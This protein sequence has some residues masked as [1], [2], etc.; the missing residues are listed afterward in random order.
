DGYFYLMR[1]LI[2]DS[3]FKVNEETSMV[4]AWISFPN[5]LPTFFVEECL[6][7][8]A[9]A[10]GKPIHLDQATINKTRPSCA[11]VKVL[12]D[13]KSDFPKAIQMNIDNIEMG[14]IRSNMVVI[15][16]D[17]VPKY[18]F[19]CKMQGHDKEN[20]KVLNHRRYKEHN[21]Q[22][23]QDKAQINHELQAGKVQKIHKGSSRILSSGRV[24]G[25]PGNWNVVRDR[26][27]KVD[28]APQLTIVVENKFEDLALDDP[29]EESNNQQN[30]DTSNKIMCNG[31]NDGEEK[32]YN[33]EDREINSQRNMDMEN[34]EVSSSSVE[35]YKMHGDKQDEERQETHSD[36]VPAGSTDLNSTRLEK[37]GEIYNAANISPR[38]MAVVKSARKGKKRDDGEPPQT[39]RVQP[40]KQPATCINR[41]RKRLRM[42]KVAH[43]NNGK[44]WVFTNHGYD[45]TTV[46]D[47]DQQLTVL[48]IDQNDA[49]NFYATLVYAECDTNQGMELWD[50]LYQLYG[51]M[52]RLCLIVG[53]FN[54]VLN[55]DEKIGGLPIMAT[56]YEDFKT[57]IESCDLNQVQ[58]K[59]SPFT[60]SNY[61]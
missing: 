38:A 17:Y 46:S 23:T 39:L 55:R 24:V 4:M 61:I 31:E 44:I 5:L 26:R 48:L 21:T 13:R 54:V 42:P 33:M 2:D 35:H 22:L 29:A 36:E 41:N 60:W 27:G 47:T 37:H 9:L 28:R 7:S 15:Q 6:F 30:D 45:I 34:V 12:V 18:Y 59:G 58:F 53:D 56:D 10:I 25:D 16:Y 57:C 20:C 32:S 11:R 14:E 51:G 19:E 8:L 40:R 3:R 43:N 52:D 49:H 1:P 50:D